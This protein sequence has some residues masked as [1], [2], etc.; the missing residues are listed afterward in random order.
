L[1]RQENSLQEKLPGGLRIHDRNTAAVTKQI[2][3][4][5]ANIS[6]K[7]PPNALPLF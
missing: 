4:P 3:L 5:K 7:A 1:I 6:G 2:G